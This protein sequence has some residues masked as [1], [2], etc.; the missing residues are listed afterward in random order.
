MIKICNHLGTIGIT[1][2]Y[3]RSL[4]SS[5]VQSSFGVAEMNFYGPKQGVELML[6]KKSTPNQ[7]VIIR[8][9]DN[10]L[11][12]DLHISVI[13]GVNVNAISES[14][15]HKVDYVVTEQ[16]GVEVESVNVYVDGMVNS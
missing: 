14:V 3:L 7:G 10:K 4:I 6:G 13:Y 1:V 12:I 16:A 9:R 15:A 11:I 8:T 2:G 5:T